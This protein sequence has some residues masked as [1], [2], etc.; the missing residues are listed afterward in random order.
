MTTIEIN[1]HTKTKLEQLGKSLSPYLD[2]DSDDYNELIDIL[3]QV[4]D[5]HKLKAE[6]NE[7][8]NIMEIGYK[9]SSVFPIPLLI[10]E[11]KK[12]CYNRISIWMEKNNFKSYINT[13]VIEYVKKCE[14]KFL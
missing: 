6:Y 8:D 1:I 11:L 13:D 9:N 10:F 3:L 4:Y 5:N 2:I 7:K 12:G 14:E